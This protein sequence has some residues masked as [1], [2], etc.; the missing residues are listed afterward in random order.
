MSSARLLL[1]SMLLDPHNPE[2]D[3]GR[4]LPHVCTGVVRVFKLKPRSRILDQD[5][6]V[7]AVG[8][9]QL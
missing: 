3:P 7:L 5:G 1:T 8:R 6:D 2:P 4:V 9:E